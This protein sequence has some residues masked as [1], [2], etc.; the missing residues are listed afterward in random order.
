MKIATIFWLFL[1]FILFWEI[2]LK[3]FVAVSADTL[4]G[5]NLPWRDYQ[6]GYQTGV[7]VKNPPLSDVFSQFVPWR[8]IIAQSYR[9]GTLPLWNPY[10]FSGN[11]FLATYQTAVLFPANILLIVLPLLHGW[12]LHIILS[13]FCAGLFMAWYLKS[14]ITS[15]PAILVGSVIYA[16]SGLMTTWVEYGTAVWA[17]SFI[18]LL[19]LTIDRFIVTHKPSLLQAISGLVFLTISAGASQ[20]TIYL[21]IILPSY[22]LFVHRL[23]IKDLL[24]ILISIGL[25][26][27]LAGLILFPTLEFTGRSIRAAEQFSRTINYSLTPVREIIRIWAPDFFGSP[28]TYNHWG[29]ASYQ[30]NSNF[31]GTLGLVLVLTYIFSKKK[32][33]FGSFFVWIFTA[34]L[35]LGYANPLSS[36]IFSKNLP[37]L[38]FSSASRIFFLL[39]LSGS[40]ISAVSL[41]RL[42]SKLH[43]PIGL[44]IL[45]LIILKNTPP[46]FIHI[47]LRN[48]LFPLTQLLIVIVISLLPR[49]RKILPLIILILVVFDMSRYF[50]KFTPIISR[51]LVFPTTPV[52]DHLKHNLTGFRLIN[53]TDE[54]IP[55]NTW[56]YY[57]LSS[58]EG[59]DPL[60]SLNYNRFFKVAAGDDYYAKPHRY[61]DMRDARPE[62]LDILSVKYLVAKT[63]S[64]DY[65]TPIKA[66]VI[67]AGWKSDFTDKSVEIYINPNVLPKVTSFTKYRQFKSEADLATHLQSSEF[68]PRSEIFLFPPI[69]DLPL[70][71]VSAKINA[72]TDMPN[73]LDIQYLAT[74]SALLLVSQSYDPSWIATLNGTK[75]PV[76]RAD[77]GLL[78]ISAPP[79]ANMTIKLRYFPFSL[80]WG[81]LFTALS[82][83][84][85]WL[86]AKIMV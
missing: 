16:T 53:E 8:Q 23:R 32:S 6:W 60:Y 37:L 76:L 25:G 65:L 84:L 56:A 54:I 28:V 48:S 17:M 42:K 21:L 67:S 46:Q 73:G 12:N 5:A 19:L 79:S 78:A 72:I 85:V 24:N 7:P 2:F 18:P 61:L 57:G 75:L 10:S 62:F 52:I 68:S 47:G 29:E 9:L 59:Y 38:T 58:P 40:V 22:L 20:I 11:A 31:I 4:V 1:V 14:K 50:R 13:V 71:F 43:V 45:T 69:P 26:V 27:G 36:W 3:G 80:L 55:P 63:R 34:S 66:R 64:D 39:T 51:N 86:R 74:N 44:V 81:G 35:V 77:G 41:D 83:T 33:R 30:E 49:F 70:N 82:G 15:L